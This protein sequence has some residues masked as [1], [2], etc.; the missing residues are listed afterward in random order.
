[1]VGILLCMYMLAAKKNLIITN[2]YMLLK[3][4]V[5]QVQEMSDKEVV[6]PN[7]E[8]IFLEWIQ[9]KMS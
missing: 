9:K 8:E 2:T 7:D 6:V 4:K 3:F 1:M 5:P